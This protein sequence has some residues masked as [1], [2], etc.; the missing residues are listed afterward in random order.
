MTVHPWHH[1]IKQDEIRDHSLH[2]FK[3]LSSIMSKEYL[4][5]C[6]FQRELQNIL[7]SRFVFNNQYLLSQTPLLSVPMWFF[8]YELPGNSI[9]FF[10]QKIYPDS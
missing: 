5:A 2:V 1:K 9:Y 8:L 7:N 6:T 4:V 10:Q 3:G